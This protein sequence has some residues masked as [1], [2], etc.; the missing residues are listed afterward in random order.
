[1]HSAFGHTRSAV[2]QMHAHLTNFVCIWSLLVGLTKC[3][4]HLGK[5]AKC[6]RVW[7]IAVTRSQSFFLLQISAIGQ[8][9][10]CWPNARAIY[11]T[12]RIWSNAI[13]QMRCAFGQMR[14]LVKCAFTGIPRFNILPSA[15]HISAFYQHPNEEKIQYIH[16]TECQQDPNVCN[17]QYNEKHTHTH[18]HTHLLYKMLTIF[19][20]MFT[21]TDTRSRAAGATGNK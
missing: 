18:S 12:L 14:R 1:M 21:K 7:P 3:A 20:F 5:C 15:F 19:V 13:G 11:Q 16:W 6:A 9:R 10:V 17:V 8:M 2:G 4:A